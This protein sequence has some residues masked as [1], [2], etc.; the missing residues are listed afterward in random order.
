MLKRF[1]L[2]TRRVIIT[3]L[4]VV[5]IYAV[6]LING[7]VVNTHLTMTSYVPS[8]HYPEYPVIDYQG[9]TP[10]QI[11]EIKRGEYLAKA[12][13]CIACHSNQSS[14]GKP[15]AGG[16][17]MQT[18][19]GNLY[20]PN[21][22]PDKET[23]IGNWS[24]E[25]FIT[26]MREGV[27][28]DG[29]YYFP[30]FPYLY[31]NQMTVDDVLSIKAYLDLIPAVKQPNRDNEMLFPFNWR[32]LQLGWRILFFYPERTGP[33]Q[34]NTNQSLDWN[35]GA[36]LVQGLG[37]C[38]MCHTPSYYLI[39]ENVSMGAPIRKYDLTGAVIQGYLAPNITH[40]NLG[41][42]PDKE[43]LKVFEEYEMIGG[44]SVQGPMEEAIHNSLRHLTTEDL[45]AM[46]SYLK[47]VKSELPKPVTV[48]A[49]DVGKVIYNNYC[50]GCHSTGVGDA[51][52]ISDAAGW[53]IMANS[54]VDKLYQVA[55]YGGG[56]MPAKGTCISCSNYQIKLA[57]DYMI[58]ESKRLHA[59]TQ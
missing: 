50:S 32:F 4:I 17:P 59:A 11:A 10:A 12:G 55:I 40:S 49:T 37:H 46:I 29:Q 36:Y 33:Y 43:L 6:Y 16:L 58:A 31:F 8:G 57:V 56:N 21:I 48:K 30:A 44:N 18:P 27:M 14:G 38:S 45:L 2:N 1:S 52:K 51:P 39:N 7:V 3:T 24:N 19:F 22:T 26:A 41:A 15:F 20:T 23:G 9:K 13:D 34:T 47:S 54:G 53:Q 28:P 25:D 42:I 35:R 5:F